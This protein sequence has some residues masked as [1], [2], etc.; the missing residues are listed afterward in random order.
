MRN[1][2]HGK[3]RIMTKNGIARRTSAERSSHEIR[4]WIDDYNDIFS[5]FDPREYTERNISDDFLHEMKRVASESD[6]DV[7]T[8]RLLVDEK[9][10]DEKTEATIIERVHNEF[11]ES[12]HVYEGKRRKFRSQSMLFIAAGLIM[13]LSAGYFSY[14]KADQPLMHIP[15][16]ILEPAGWFLTWTGFEQI[17]KSG[18]QSMPEFVFFGKLRRTK[19]VFGNI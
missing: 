11:A 17:F 4:I 12:Y 9:L 1:L 16:V 18:K 8:L 13:I 5:D 19:I 2:D 15:L 7:K 10:R 3:I 14:L 6:H